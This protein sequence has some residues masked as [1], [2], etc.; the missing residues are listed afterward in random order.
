MFLSYSPDK[1]FC[2]PK[3]C[4]VRIVDM[5]SS[6]RLP[7]SAI[8]FKDNLVPNGDQSFKS[9]LIHSNS[10]RVFGSKFVHDAACDTDAGKDG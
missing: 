6:A 3:A 1:I 10:L 2:V 5:T 4:A 7:P 8:C 9:S